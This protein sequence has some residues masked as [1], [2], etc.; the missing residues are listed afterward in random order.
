MF[1]FLTTTIPKKADVSLPSRNT[2]LVATCSYTDVHPLCHPPANLTAA[3][4]WAGLTWTKHLVPSG[5]SCSVSAMGSSGLQPAE[6]L[7]N[8]TPETAK[9]CQL[10]G[11]FMGAT[12]RL[13]QQKSI[14]IKH[15]NSMVCNLLLMSA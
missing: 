15:S 11:A 1:F 10:V 9:S 5:A 12:G 8:Y 14:S 4:P 6:P 13:Q 7:G 2:A 3:L